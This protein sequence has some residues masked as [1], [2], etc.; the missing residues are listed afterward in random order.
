MFLDSRSLEIGR[1]CPTLF[2]EVLNIM[3]AFPF[4]HLEI[5]STLLPV[6]HFSFLSQDVTFALPFSTKSVGSFDKLPSM[7]KDQFNV[8]FLSYWVLCMVV[9]FC[10][11]IARNGYCLCNSGLYVVVPASRY[12]KIQ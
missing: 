12:R 5:P 11:R 2:S 1:S 8:T 10:G 9:C 6:F 4:H 7:D 3:L